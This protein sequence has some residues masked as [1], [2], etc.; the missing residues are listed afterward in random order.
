MHIV[1]T[2][3]G[4]AGHVTPAI[5]MIEEYNFGERTILNTFSRKL[6]EYIRDK[7]GDK[8]IQ[9][10]YFPIR[11][12]KPGERDPYSYAYCACICGM[13]D[14]STS[15]E[16]ALQ[17]VKETGVRPWAGAF[18]KDEATV[19]VAVA[20]QAELITCNNVDEVLAILRAKTPCRREP[21]HLFFPEG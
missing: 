2:G 21:L 5:A 13:K 4:T 10:V 7:Y 15:V 3:G 12:M 6:H 11:Y 16:E 19:D 18:V 20:L 1:F 14:G 17:F 8:Y 9:H